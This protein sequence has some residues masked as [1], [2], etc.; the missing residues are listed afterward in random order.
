MPQ[1]I[2]CKVWN[3]KGAEKSKT[4]SSQIS[5]SI[6]Y[7]LNDEK[8]DTIVS[9]ENSILN[10]VAGQLSRECQYVAN[11]VKTLKRT[12]TGVVNLSSIETASEEMMEVKSF[13]N[14]FDGRSALHGVISLDELESDISKAPELMKLCEELLITLFPNHQAVFAVHTNTENMH[15]H[16]I[17]NSVGMDGRK[18]HQPEKFISNTV[19]P[20]L[21]RLAVKY[22]FTPNDKWDKK[23]ADRNITE[24]ARIKIQ[25][26]KDIDLA[27][28]KS[29]DFD[30]FKEQLESMGLTVH[31]GKYMSLKYA[32][33]TKPIRSYQLGTNYTIEAIT[34]RLSTKYNRLEN[35]GITENIVMDDNNIDDVLTPRIY[36]LK[37]YSSLSEKEKKQVISLL[38]LGRNPW[39]EN[40][41]ANWQLNNIANEL[42]Q[43]NRIREY[44]H[45]YSNAG[46]V[47]ECLD[48][49]LETKK[50]IVKE[51]KEL[52]NI[53]R[54]YKPIL[55]IY[56]QM[57]EIE[58]KAYLYEHENVPEYKLDFEK[59]RELTKRL[60]D[61]YHKDVYE[62]A[63][64]LNEYN[65]RILYATAMLNELSSQ[66]REVRRYGLKYGL[67]IKDNHSL[68]DVVEFYS[69]KKDGYTGI[70]DAESFF[71]VSDDS[72]QI[73]RITKTPTYDA[74]GRIVES[75]DIDVLTQSGNTIHSYEGIYGNKAKKVLSFLEEQCNFNNNC[76]KVQKFSMAKELVRQNSKPASSDKE[77]HANLAQSENS[78]DNSLT[79]TEAIN[80]K[81]AKEQEGYH[82]IRNTEPNGYWMEVITSA[83]EI[84]LNVVN[85]SNEML[86]FVIIPGVKSST[87][88]G[89]DKLMKLKDKYNFTD[90]MTAFDT[91]ENAYKKDMHEQGKEMRQ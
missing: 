2:T 15:I 33:M 16:F 80:L 20:V 76:K 38:R 81:S 18:I 23:F 61:G 3:I 51:K 54:K 89:F 25:M 10:D 32:D 69:D 19:H 57:V 35:G 6:N 1:G 88:E 65:E 47:Q 21:N 43:E 41:K 50:L 26:R 17:V 78:I 13:F 14:K 60:K 79:Y 64:F 36:K 9:F 4:T 28:E 75:Y 29:T 66:Y 83:A 31:V 58:K 37:K 67:I 71:I 49:I 8:T 62:V 77:L 40:T 24:Y 90:E 68:T 85:D 44:M 91:I 27:I 22:G 11:D 39:R 84:R 30:E 87:S 12:L 86:D 56:K 63:D 73:L 7:I 53:K 59:Y 82:V 72:E 74:K 46:T 34:E 52:T 55:D 45:Y 48:N 70:F 5:D 42:N